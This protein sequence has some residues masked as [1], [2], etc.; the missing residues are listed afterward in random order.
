MMSR[1][2]C[3]QAFL[4]LMLAAGFA[5][6]VHPAAPGLQLT[7]QLHPEEGTR[8]ETALAAARDTIRKR[9]DELGLSDAAVETAGTDRLSIRFPDVEDPE[10]VRRVLLSEAVLELRLVRFPTEGPDL[11]S[12]DAV[13]SHYEG[14]LPSDL[15][16][17]KQEVR[18]DNGQVAEEKFFAVEK[19]PVITGRDIAAASPSTG[20]IREPI[21][22]FR[23]KP[24]AA[25]VFSEVTGANI[26]SR[27]AIVLDGRVVSAPMI[28]S[29]IGDTGIIEGGFT[30]EQALELAITLSSGPL[31]AGL[32]VVE[33]KRVEPGRR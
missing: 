20:P 15:E 5:G 31:P 1:P 14:R 2:R 7:L 6:C 13:L 26:G 28:N 11:A 12:E 33:A 32:T 10:R 24:E 18:G 27:I 4:V 30:S 8:A 19:K 29:R 3:A 9:L 22:V 16:I 25:D 23:L 21:V 17:L